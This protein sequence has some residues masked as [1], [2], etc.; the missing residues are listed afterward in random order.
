M[1]Q[2]DFNT[3]YRYASEILD[4]RAVTPLD[5]MVAGLSLVEWRRT[6]AKRLIDAANLRKADGINPNY[7]DGVIARANGCL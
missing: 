2:I 3:G 5:L 6:T 4:D 7:Q 1:N